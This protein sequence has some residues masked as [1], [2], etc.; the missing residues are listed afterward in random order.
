[1]IDIE[2]FFVFKP[3]Q[4]FADFMKFNTKQKYSAYI[5]LS[6]EY[7]NKVP[8]QAVNLMNNETTPNAAEEAA[9]IIDEAIRANKEEGKQF[10]TFVDYFLR[11][12]EGLGAQ[13][14]E[15]DDVFFSNGGQTITYTQ[16]RDAYICHL[17]SPSIKFAAE[18]FLDMSYN[19]F[20]IPKSIDPEDT[21]YD[22]KQDFIA[23]MTYSKYRNKY[24]EAIFR[25]ASE[26]IEYIIPTLINIML[27]VYE[28]VCEMRDGEMRDDDDD[29][30]PLFEEEEQE[31]GEEQ[32]VLE[33]HEEQ[34]VREELQEQ[35]GENDIDQR[36][37]YEQIWKRYRE[38]EEDNSDDE[39]L[40]Y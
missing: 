13:Y 7:G 4:L 18:M 32:Q 38:P 33:E 28:T 2:D 10:S 21:R 37:Y 40:L 12:F 5:C 31:Y 34:Y 29:F 39:D 27:H 15:E 3:N 20:G 26:N 11:L 22:L 25:A 6:D 23:V 9:A 24:K 17:P 35:P 30:R 16:I 19:T 36:E 8:E 14:L 1:M